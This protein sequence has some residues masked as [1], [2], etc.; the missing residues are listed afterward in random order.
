MLRSQL[1]LADGQ[2]L[3]IQR[4]RLPIPSLLL[5]QRRQ[6]VQTRPCGGMLRSLLPLADGQRPRI[7]RLRLSTPSLC[8]V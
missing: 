1:P 5:I 2:R 6:I 3:R 8:L 7:Q 4:L